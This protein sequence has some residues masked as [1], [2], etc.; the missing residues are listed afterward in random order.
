MR[1]CAMSGMSSV[2]AF[3]V[4]GILAILTYQAITADGKVTFLEVIVALVIGTVAARLLGGTEIIYLYWGGVG[5][6]VAWWMAQSNDNT[7]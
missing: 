3:A 2:D 6:G 4:A 5:A 7:T 1:R